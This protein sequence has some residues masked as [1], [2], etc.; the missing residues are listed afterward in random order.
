MRHIL[1]ALVQNVPGVLAHISGML[2][3]RG[4]NI[5]SLAVG[6]T[7][8]PQ[9]SRMTFVV[10]GDN[11]VLEQVRKQ[12]E[13]VVTVVGVHNISSQDHVD[14]DLMLLKVQA[15][16]G[17]QRSEVRELVDIFRARI[18]DVGPDDVMIEI[19]GRENKLNAFMER[20]RPYGILEVVRSGC[21]AMVR[22]QAPTPGSGTT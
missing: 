18:V 6:E 10:V 4:Y 15:S 9:I 20:L 5:H 7:D 3:S 1:S 11:N 22:S 19:S 17:G 12:L 21:I 2:A 16:A 14:R 13:K 8:D